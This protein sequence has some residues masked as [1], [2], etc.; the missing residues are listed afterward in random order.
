MPDGA[1][2]HKCGEFRIC[3]VCH[4]QS[5]ADARKPCAKS[6]DQNVHNASDACRVHLCARGVRLIKHRTEFDQRN[7]R[8]DGKHTAQSREY[9]RHK[10]TH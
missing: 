8:G 1:F 9:S 2:T 5:N 3:K 7:V 4:P 6:T 10:Q